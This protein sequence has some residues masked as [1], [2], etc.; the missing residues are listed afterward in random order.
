MTELGTIP[1]GGHYRVSVTA[2]GRTVTHRDALSASCITVPQPDP[3]QG[4][5]AAVFVTHVVSPTPVETHVFLQLQARKAM[6]V[7]AGDHIWSIV[8]GRIE[9]RGLLKDL[10]KGALLR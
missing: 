6:M 2:D 10:G 3:T 4:E 5:L 8:D 9:D 1:V 7:A